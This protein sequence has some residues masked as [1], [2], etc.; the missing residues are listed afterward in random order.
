[1]FDH[2]PRDRSEDARDSVDVHWVKLG[3]GP[4]D[5]DPR[6]FLDTR[7]R[8]RSSRDRDPRDPFIATLELPLDS[9]VSH[10]IVALLVFAITRSR[11]PLCSSSSML[12]A[13][14]RPRG[15]RAAFGH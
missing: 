14:L 9:D 12:F 10:I 5:E 4:S 13:P 3:R 11:M 1:M 8:D 6:D 2:D 7:E 15:N